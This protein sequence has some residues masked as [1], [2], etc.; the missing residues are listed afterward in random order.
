LTKPFFGGWKIY[1][2]KGSLAEP[3]SISPALLAWRQL[4][5]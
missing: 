1:H 4:I 5:G 2:L 3:F